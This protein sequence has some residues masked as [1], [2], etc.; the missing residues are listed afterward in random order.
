MLARAGDACERLVRRLRTQGIEVH[1]DAPAVRSVQQL[2]QQAT[3]ELERRGFYG[4]VAVEVFAGQGVER[5]EVG[6][7]HLPGLVIVS[8]PE[9]DGTRKALPRQP[10]AG[11]QSIREFRPGHIGPRGSFGDRHPAGPQ[12]VAQTSAH[13]FALPARPSL[14][15]A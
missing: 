13:R 15:R 4:K 5:G 9:A 8:V 6:I 10:M 11:S 2:R 7:C 14:R 1:A 12:H 3:I